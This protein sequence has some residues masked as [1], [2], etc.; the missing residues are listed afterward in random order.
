MPCHKANEK[1]SRQGGWRDAHSGRRCD[2]E[3]DRAVHRYSKKHNVYL[4]AALQA[5][6]A[7]DPPQESLQHKTVYELFDGSM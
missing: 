1:G 7:F 2:V 5:P 4:T 6:G 3:A